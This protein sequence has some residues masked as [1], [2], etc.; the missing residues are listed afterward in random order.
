MTTI[1]MVILITFIVIALL[2][3]LRGFFKGLFRSL[4]DIGFLIATMFLSVL[5]SR[6]AVGHFLTMERAVSLLQSSGIL[7]SNIVSILDEIQTGAT[8]SVDMIFGLISIIITP[9]VFMVVY[10][11]LGLIM[12]IP[13]LI[14]QKLVIPKPKNKVFKLTGGAV[15]ALRYVVAL[16]IFLIPIVGY[17]NLVS[18]VTEMLDQMQSSTEVVEQE[19]ESLE[20]EEP[21]EE[22]PSP[23]AYVDEIANNGAVRAIR[24]CGGK[25]IFNLL[26]TKKVGDVKIVLANEITTTLTLYDDV[27]DITSLGAEATE[28]EKA[29]KIE[30]LEA[31]LE[32]ERVVTTIVT[33]LISYVATEWNEGGT[34]FGIEK[35]TLEASFGNTLDAVI[36][37]L[38]GLDSDGIKD[39]FSTGIDIYYDYKNHF[40]GQEIL[41][42][43]ENPEMWDDV[44]THIYENE[45]TRPLISAISDDI[46]L[47]LRDKLNE[48]ETEFVP[49]DMTQITEQ[50]IDNEAVYL[51]TTI[52]D[53]MA[54]VNSIDADEH[55]SVI[56]KDGNFAA[57]GRALN[58]ARESFMVNRTFSA[59]VETVI[60]SSIT[61]NFG[62]FDQAFIDRS[63]DPDADFEAMLVA[64]Q[65]V[66]LLAI[67]LQD[68]ETT[69]EEKHDA[70]NNIVENAFADDVTLKELLT[71][72]NMEKYGISSGSSN[73]VATVVNSLLDAVHD[74]EFES[75]EQK[76]EEI[77]KVESVMSNI[78]SSTQNTSS[79]ENYFSI[80][81]S[82]SLS[83]QSAG[84]FVD[85]I[86]DSTVSSAMV[87]NSAYD[88]AGNPVE[89]P[90]HI[91]GSLT[92]ADRLA[93]QEELSTRLVGASEE[94]AAVLNA[95]AIVFGVEIA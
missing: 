88:E 71:E 81:G 7:P 76:Q 4:V 42:V 56:I 65:N 89:D 61:D 62:F 14:L 12:K 84:E 38:A 67:A 94:D 5:I 36:D 59:L 46:I 73:T 90:Y 78:V 54:F 44:L 70:I 8:G 16:A 2:G 20:D 15:G 66:A 48:D 53:M 55:I 80:D 93:M 87:L 74:S 72:E 11:V 3:F 82:E 29:E 68:N 47:I 40:T 63:D 10:L 37:L 79:A 45:D 33:G 86:M 50:D 95:I 21:L 17:V 28:E 58:N 85:S 51:S 57:L 13:K 31:D 24:A 25:W 1:A 23:M 52:S 83:G 6:W 19:G 26:T 69:A 91:Q 30:Q 64:R 49:L 9:I 60:N 35:P 43:I 41:T 34:P 39:L 92:E 27:M 77:A 22:A 75:E 32:G 18:D